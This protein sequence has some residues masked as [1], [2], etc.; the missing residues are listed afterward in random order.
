M[1]IDLETEHLTPYRAILPLVTNRKVLDVGCGQ[2]GGDAILVSY[3]K[4][5]TA[6]D[7]SPSVIEKAREKHCENKNNLNLNQLPLFTI[8][9]RLKDC[10]NFFAICSLDE[11]LDL[12]H[13]KSK[14]FKKMSITAWGF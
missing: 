14:L 10:L 11:K 4:K 1:K 13:V 12:S 3:A 2:G 9:D 5:V 8:K 7:I 6:I